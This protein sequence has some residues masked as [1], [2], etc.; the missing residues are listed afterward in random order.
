MASAPQHRGPDL[1]SR[2][3]LGERINEV[4]RP[5]LEALG[6][7]L[8]AAREDAGLTRA[9]LADAVGM[10]RKSIWRIEVGA[11]RT[12]VRTLA[13]MAQVIGGSPEELVGEL[14]ELGGSAIAPESL[15]VDRIERRRLRRARRIEVLAQREA[16]VLERA[17]LEARWAARTESHLRFRAAMRLIDVSFRELR[18]I[19]HL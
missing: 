7:R 16:Y 13:A 5:G 19:G 1:V 3:L 4:E 2:P 6:Q 14:I 17:A 9:K 18:R 12:R 15:Y 8:Q 11:R 10:N